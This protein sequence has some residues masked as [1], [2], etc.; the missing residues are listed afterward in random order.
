MTPTQAQID[1]AAEALLR[2]E[3]LFGHTD[4][5]ALAKAA[6][7]AAAEG[8]PTQGEIPPPSGSGIDTAR[9]VAAAAQVGDQPEYL[10]VPETRTLSRYEKVVAATIERCVEIVEAHDHHGLL[11]PIAAAI[12]A[13]KDRP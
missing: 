9:A 5:N 10:Y 4:F 6:L 3:I 2:F 1:A 11:K 7:T 8:G 13:L 12:R